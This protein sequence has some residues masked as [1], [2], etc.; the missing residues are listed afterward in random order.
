MDW[1]RFARRYRDELHNDSSKTERL[2]ALAQQTPLILMSQ[3]RDP[4][5]SWPQILQEFLIKACQQERDG[6]ASERV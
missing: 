2:L 4:D 5:Q 1:P 6:Q 3:E